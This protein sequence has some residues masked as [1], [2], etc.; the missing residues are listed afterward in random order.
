MQVEGLIGKKLGM[1]QLFEDDGTAVPVT[2]L[3]AGPCVVSFVRTEERDG[4]TAAQLALVDPSASK[5]VNKPMKGHFEKS[6]LPPARKLREFKILG[7]VKVGDAFGASEFGE[8]E[9][10]DVT[11]VSK[12]LGFTGV[13]RRFGFGGGRATHGSM[14]H[15]APGSIGASAYPSRVMAGMGMPGRSGGTRVTTKNLKVVRVDSDNNLLI[16]RGAVPGKAGSQ[17][18]IRRAKAGGRKAK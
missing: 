17:V 8:G 4:Y 11:G 2:V 14:F 15:R 7:E 9:L 16:V 6:K 5:H 13:I 10:V 3:Q 18:M 1:T 12:G